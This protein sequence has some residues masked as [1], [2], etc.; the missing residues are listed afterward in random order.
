MG[1]GDG[2]NGEKPWWR[3]L[4]NVGKLTYSHPLDGGALFVIHGIGTTHETH[5]ERESRG[6]DRCFFM[7][8]FVVDF[9]LA[10]IPPPVLSLT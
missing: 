4:N 6:S 10:P 2:R 3:A 1:R 5:R 9:T 8:V 7:S